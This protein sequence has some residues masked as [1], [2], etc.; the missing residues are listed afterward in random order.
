MQV[1]STIQKIE[2]ERR[3]QLVIARNWVVLLSFITA[4]GLGPG[5]IAQLN[6][7]LFIAAVLA[8]VAGLLVGRILAFLSESSSVDVLRES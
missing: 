7:D 5:L 6:L 3:Q 1:Q 2:R 4:I 8:V